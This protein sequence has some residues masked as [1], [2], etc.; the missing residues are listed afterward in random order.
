[1]ILKLRKEKANPK[2]DLEHTHMQTPPPHTSQLEFAS[3]G[4]NKNVRVKN[5][6]QSKDGHMWKEGP[7]CWP[8]CMAEH[9]VEQCKTL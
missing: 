5:M 3:S 2:S 6:F 1:M 7:I 9:V 8:K 4:T